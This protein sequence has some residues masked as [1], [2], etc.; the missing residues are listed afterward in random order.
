VGQVTFTKI[1]AGDAAAAAQVESFFTSAETESGNIQASNLRQ[2]GVDSRIIQDSSV[3]SQVSSATINSSDAVKYYNSGSGDLNVSSASVVVETTGGAGNRLEITDLGSVDTT[4]EV[5]RV[6]WSVC[7]RSIDIAGSTEPTVFFELWQK[8]DGLE[9]RIAGTRR[10]VKY[11]FGGYGVTWGSDAVSGSHI[12]SAEGVL[13]SLSLRAGIE[14]NG[15]YFYLSE[16][17]LIA[18]RFKH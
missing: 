16:G 2:E 12:L 6:R 14:S 4:T 7:L 1:S 9:E 11:D 15:D 8:L 17:S 10:R 13:S 5:I 3:V 18:T